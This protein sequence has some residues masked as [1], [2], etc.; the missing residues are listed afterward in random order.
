MAGRGIRTG[1]G[2][3]T[4]REPPAVTVNIDECEHGLPQ[5]I[6][7]RCNGSDRGSPANS[8]TSLA[9]ATVSDCDQQVKIVD[10]VT[11][12][13]IATAA[14]VHDLQKGLVEK[15]AEPAKQ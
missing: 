7:A 5:F 9:G 3:I 14:E 8:S 10:H 1:C 13:T 12:D 4:L 15:T 11:F 2:P 6:C